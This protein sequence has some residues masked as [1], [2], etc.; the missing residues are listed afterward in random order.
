MKKILFVSYDGLT[1][2]LGQSQII[3]YLAGLTKYGYQFT[4]LSCDKPDKYL[5]HKERIENIL[6]S[7]PIKW[8]SI[9]YHKNPPVLSSIYDTMM[10]KRKARQLHQEDTFD[11]VH[12]RAGTPAIVGLWMKQKFGVKY[13]NDLRDFFAD[14]RIDS[15]SWNL[16]NPVYRAVYRYLKNKESESIKSNDGIVCLT[17][18]AEKIIREW[19][20][21]KKNIPLKVIPCSVDTELFNPKKID[22][23]T[24][25]KIREELQI[26]EGDIIISYLGSIG[27]WYLTE[28]MMAFCKII[29]DENPGTRFLFI[30]P[31]QHEIIF[32]M[33]RKHSIS[34]NKILVRHAQRDDVPIL[35]S[36]STYSIFFIKP[37]YSK[38][39][40][41]PTKHGEIMAMGIPLVTNKGVG[42]VAEIVQNYNSG[43]V[44]NNFEKE[45]LAAAAKLLSKGIPFDPE[46]IRA[47][48]LE[49]YDLQNAIEKYKEIY[50]LILT[51]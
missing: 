1:D 46:R 49:Y 45:S 43:I 6:R 15:G 36:L 23:D 11:M 7:Y 30:T 37:C 48:A 41:S 34:E 29:S 19:P 31:H 2:P 47:G 10:L 50:L 16:K 18:T 44:L 51:E 12:T 22:Q 32:E 25:K 17:H 3:P 38:Q 24:K 21:Y 40:S 9:P 35:L 28:E 8:V 13:L 27:G 20:E 39:A 4:I 26:A 42:D 33:A 5:L 14:S